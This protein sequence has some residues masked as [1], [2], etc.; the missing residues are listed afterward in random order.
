MH[1]FLDDNRIPPDLTWYLARSYDE[2]VRI[3][4]KHGF[5]DHVSFDH[6]LGDGP[7]GMDFAHWLVEIDLDHD[8]MPVNFTFSVHSANPVGKA[9]I[10]G[11]LNGYIGWKRS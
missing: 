9:N 7:S 3:V 11:L 10:E 4:Q 8:I 6:D 2:A 5:P 1:L